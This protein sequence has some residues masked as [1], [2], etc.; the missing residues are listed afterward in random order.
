MKKQK[1][2]MMNYMTQDAALKKSDDVRRAREIA[3]LQKEGRKEHIIK[4]LE[5]DARKREAVL[6]RR[7][8]EVRSFNPKLSMQSRFTTTC[9]TCKLPQATN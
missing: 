1:V 5:A 6:K 9:S 8:E 3:Q 2:K 4:L 7:Q